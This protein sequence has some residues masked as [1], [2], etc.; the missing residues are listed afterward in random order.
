MPDQMYV[1]ITL[2]KPVT[3]PTQARAIYELVK[4]RLVDRP[5]VDIT[6]HCTN[7]FSL[8]EPT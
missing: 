4:Q 7:H 6:G 8:E 1:V 3:D 5:D 2:R